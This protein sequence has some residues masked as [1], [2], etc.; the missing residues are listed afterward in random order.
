M[1]ISG[2]TRVVGLFGYPVSHS[3]SPLMQNTAFS[4]LG[5]DWTYV[6]FSVHP[7]SIKLAI[8]S[9][10][11]L[12]LVGVNVTVPLKE[13]IAEHLDWVDP[14]A[15]RIKSVNTIVNNNGELHGFSTDGAGLMWDLADKGALPP[16]DS[17]VLIL[18]AGGSARAVVWAMVEAGYRVLI[19]NRTSERAETL[20]SDLGVNAAVVSW[21]SVSLAKACEKADLI[22]NTT[23]FG[24]KPEDDAAS[25]IIAPGAVRPEAVLYDLIYAP[26]VTNLMRL[27]KGCGATS[28]NGL[29]MLVRQ[30]A[31]SLR[32][33][34]GIPKDSLPVFEMEQAIT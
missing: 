25:A 17:F 12:D 22:V 2:K 3:R 19:A 5:L 26:P 4:A 15:S 32:L 31:L 20:V 34:S 10:R 7:S 23:T 24:M 11:A 9:V 8:P 33:W 16:P 18:G 1:T 6:S 27:A 14:V 13:L 28:Y 21:D 29:G 30:G